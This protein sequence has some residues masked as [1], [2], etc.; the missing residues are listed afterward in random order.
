MIILDEAS[1]IPDNIWNA[2]TP[3]RATSSADNP[4]PLLVLSTPAG[5]R[6]MFFQE[7]TSDDQ[8]WWKSAMP[9]DECPRISKEFLERE[10][11]KNPIWRQEY[12]LEFLEPEGG[13]FSAADL[14]R[15][16]Q[17]DEELENSVKPW[18][19]DF[20]VS[21]GGAERYI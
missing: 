15:V 8:I 9:A 1:R 21:G 19:D 2:I 14:D 11:I 18:M 13:L 20:V 4:I 5:R 6:G 12:F 10:K 16:F 3:M 17:M 7:W